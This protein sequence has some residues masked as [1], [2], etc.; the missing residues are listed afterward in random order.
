MNLDKWVKLVTIQDDELHHKCK[1]G[2]KYMC[3]AMAAMIT[4]GTMQAPKHLHMD[5]VMTTTTT[6]TSIANPKQPRCVNSAPPN[7]STFTDKYQS[8][9][10][11]DEC[12]VLVANDGCFAC[13]DIDI[14]HEEQGYGKCKGRLPPAAGYEMCM[15]EWVIKCH[16]DKAKGLLLFTIMVVSSVPVPLML[17]VA[18]A[19]APIVPATPVTPVAAVEVLGMTAWPIAAT[20]S[21]NA[22]LI[23]EAH[24][25]DGSIADTNLSDDSVRIMPI[26]GSEVECTLWSP[27]NARGLGKAISNVTP[28]SKP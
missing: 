8:H 15:A 22:S 13:R 9:L 23:L 12:T 2:V 3:K 24:N 16:T 27:R 18:P 21:M 14:P 6:S 1:E 19:P 10:R 5:P 28:G 4:D 26:G 25:K 17:T 7:S 20:T 11:D